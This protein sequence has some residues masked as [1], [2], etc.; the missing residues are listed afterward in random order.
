MVSSYFTCQICFTIRFFPTCNTAQAEYYFLHVKMFCNAQIIMLS[1]GETH[2]GT[3]ED[4]PVWATAP[5]KEIPRL[6]YRTWTR[7]EDAALIAAF[8]QAYGKGRS[9]GNSAQLFSCV[10][11]DCE[12]DLEDKK[13]IFPPISTCVPEPP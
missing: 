2:T 13:L 9:P 4:L 8:R 3:M 5:S 12:L 11:P 6:P 10:H 7:E 1:S